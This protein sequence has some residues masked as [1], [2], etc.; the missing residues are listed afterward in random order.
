MVKKITLRAAITNSAKVSVDNLQVD[1]DYDTGSLVI[2]SKD[3]DCNFFSCTL[4]SVEDC[5]DCDEDEDECD[6]NDDVDESQYNP[7]MGSNDFDL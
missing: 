5:F 3:E 7:Y 6:Y 4:D 1:I 2:C